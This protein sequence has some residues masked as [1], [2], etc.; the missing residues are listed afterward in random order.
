M[1]D[2]V[3]TQFQAWQVYDRWLEDSR[4]IYVDEPPTLEPAFRGVTQTN[5][6]ANKEWADA[7]LIGFAQAG[8]FQ[9]VTL[10]RAMQQK[11]IGSVLLR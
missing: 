3:L 11:A 6:P 7:Y 5:R 2:E 8:G 10:D 1:N 4:I 9:L